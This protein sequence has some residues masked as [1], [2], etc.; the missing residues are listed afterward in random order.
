MKG[1]AV[2]EPP[3]PRI[4]GDEEIRAAFEIQVKA[5][6]ASCAA[7]DSGEHWEAIRLAVAVHTLVHDASVKQKSLLT[8]LGKKSGMQFLGS[9]HDVSPRN[10]ID[11]TPLT[12]MQIGSGGARYL[13]RMDDGPP[14]VARWVP[15]RRWWQDEAI[16]SSGENRHLLSRRGLTFALRNKEGGGHFDPKVF[17]ESYTKMQDGSWVHEFNGMR[18]TLKGAELASMRQI[19]WETLKSLENAGLVTP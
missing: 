2:A 12:L 15:F 6:R 1:V 13:P 16:Y 4:R 7:Y 8:H 5:L 11:S 9:A 17:D 18:E 14:G 19:A 3:K 10:L